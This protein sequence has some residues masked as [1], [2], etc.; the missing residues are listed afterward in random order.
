MA[1]SPKIKVPDHLDK[2][3]VAQFQNC[4]EHNN[5]TSLD[6]LDRNLLLLAEVTG[7]PIDYLET[8]VETKKLKLY[9]AQVGSLFQTELSKKPKRFIRVQGKVYQAIQLASE[10]RDL[11]STDQF[12]TYSELTKNDPIKA[13][14]LVLPLMYC[15]YSL[16][17]KPVI[18][19]NQSTL[20]EIFKHAKMGDISGTA[21]FFETQLQAFMPVLQEM[22]DQAMKTINQHLQEITHGEDFTNS[23]VG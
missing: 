23:T 18:G 16:F 19:K 14:H 12:C 4:H 17:G 11:M 21:F 9:F 2:L 13:M 20:Q 22:N 7:V 1:R 10:L 8:K 3:T 5:N 15:K 6:I